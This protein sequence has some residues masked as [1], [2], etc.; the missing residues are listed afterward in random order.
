MRKGLS[1][2]IRLD[3]ERVRLFDQEVTTMLHSTIA[4]VAEAEVLSVEQKEKTR[5]RPAAMN[6]VELMRNC[7]AGLGM[8]P[9]TTLS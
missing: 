3:W 4:D 7:S 5:G 2:A 8:G 9:V 6:T 1:A